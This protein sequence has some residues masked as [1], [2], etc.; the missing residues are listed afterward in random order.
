LTGCAVD[1]AAPPEQA[2]GA[3]AAPAAATGG[4]P[5]LVVDAD[6]LAKSW[7]IYDE[8]FPS[9]SCSVQE[10]DMTPGDHR[11]LRF[12]VSTPNV[13]FGDVYVGEPLA[14]MA[15][16]DGLFEYAACHAHLHFRNYATYE[17]IDPSGG[18]VLLAAKRGFCMLDVAR[19][20][21]A[22][23]P[24]PGKWQYRS[25]GTLTTPG[26]QGISSGWADVYNKDLDGQFFVLDEASAPVAP[27]AYI[28]RITVNPPF[29]CG[30]GDEAR[31]R[32]AQGF[33]HNFAESNYGNNV[34]E[35]PVQVPGATVRATGFGPG[36]GAPAPV[37]GK[38]HKSFESD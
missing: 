11:V 26:N 33:C 12:T 9:T 21:I 2:V 25:C 18:R 37:L 27:G 34:G 4:L 31:P 3:A 13:G 30:T 6:R 32:D 29:T 14:H 28:I 7:V 16:N 35:A 23:G 8:S 5:D 22:S 1:D 17:L 15:A 20:R 24:K 19:F 10:S 38:T 36:S